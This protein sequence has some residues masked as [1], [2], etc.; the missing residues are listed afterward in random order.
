MSSLSI[1]TSSALS[2]LRAIQVQLA[3][4]SSNIANADTEGY[5]VKTA[6]KTSTVS[7]GI[8][9]GSTI[10]GITSAV[11]QN[12]VR[13]I[14]EATTAYSGAQTTSEYFES[15]TNLLG[16]LSSDSDTSGDTLA[17]LLTN[18]ETALDELATTPE[19]QT[20]AEQVVLDLV[21]IAGELNEFSSSIQELRADADQEIETTVSEVND[22]LTRIDELND[23]IVTA[24]SMGK[25]TADL[26]DQRNQEL[27]NVAEALEVSYFTDSTG[28]M[29]IY[30]SSGQVLVNSSAHLLSYDA[31]GSVSSSTTFSSITVDGK[32]ITSLVG[33]GSLGALIE[34]RDE[35]LPALQDE[36]DELAVQLR[37]TVNTI[38]NQGTSIP[39]P[40]ELTSTE[41]VAASDAFTGT[42]T[43]RVA[44]TDKDGEVVA[45]Q[46][47]DLSAYA[48]IG[49]LVSD[50]DSISGM[51]AALDA[52]GHLVLTA[53]DSD[54]GIA[55]ADV[56]SSVGSV[57][58]SDYFGFN[59]VLVGDG[60]A[61]ISVRD[62]IADDS[63]TFPI[64]VL[65]SSTTTPSVGDDVISTDSGA[66]ASA[67]ADA[68]RD[69]DFAAAGALA[70]QSGSFSD[71]AAAIVSKASIL[72]S[73]ATSAEASAETTLSV[74]ESTFQ[75]KYGVNVDEETAK[76][77]ELENAYAAS[78]QILTAV[79][80]MFE[81]LLNAV[82]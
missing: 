60:A 56:S 78:A 58:F 7:A 19:S 9:T 14:V 6:E 3:V 23:A 30:S 41:T 80:E 61:S 26:E 65:D 35:T 12:L 22:A 44:V 45:V 8:G 11:D 66:Q 46:D 70:G 42:G 17:T 18:L 63:S 55:L 69:T 33:D 62:S 79:E 57:G 47:L 64:G 82:Q 32:D 51:S 31:A 5:T 1:A 52:D 43:L 74:L 49:D 48:T 67:L 4:A 34:M 81:A 25:S 21:E 36:I 71:Y 29:S 75:S 50:L 68:L 72:A 38:A 28:R 20:L 37:D 54:N 10:T 73:T 27:L 39:T 13:N 15:I 2:S 40:E 24:Q 59:D 16:T 53:D 77:T 76:I